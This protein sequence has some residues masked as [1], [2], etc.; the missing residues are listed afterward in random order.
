MTRS[1]FFLTLALSLIIALCT[2]EGCS[3]GRHQPAT[4]L[5]TLTALARADGMSPA[6]ATQGVALGIGPVEL[7]QYVNRAQV[8]IGNTQNELQKEPFYEWAEPLETNFS[9]ILAEN[10]SLLLATDR[11]ALYPWKGPIPLDY[12]VVVEVTQFLGEPGGNVSLTALWR[13]IGPNGQDVLV[14]RKSSFQE[15]VGSQ[16]YEALAAAMSRTVAN[17]SRDIAST[18][19]SLKQAAKV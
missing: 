3:F 7:P 17:L 5:Y 16:E 2:V 8:V 18:I 11:V 13:I 19:T 15:P 12:Q 9:R 14:S 10:L 1:L 4:R 6:A